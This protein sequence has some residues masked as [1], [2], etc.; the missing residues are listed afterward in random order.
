M[1]TSDP[2]GDIANYYANLIRA[3]DAVRD[4]EQKELYAAEDK[5]LEIRR[6][7]KTLPDEFDRWDGADIC[8]ENNIQRYKEKYGE[9]NNKRDFRDHLIKEFTLNVRH[10][11]DGAYVKRKSGKISMLS[12][13]EV[14]KKVVQ[15]K[16]FID[17]VILDW[18]ENMTFSK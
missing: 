13:T 11:Y 5:Y 18:T 7:K 10:W 9:P 6:A 12:S 2:I 1:F 4:Q 3:E 16:K 14:R 17:A 15:E 8:M